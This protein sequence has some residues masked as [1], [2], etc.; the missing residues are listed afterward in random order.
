MVFYFFRGASPL[1]VTRKKCSPL[2]YACT[3]GRAEN[4]DL[5]IKRAKT[6]ICFMIT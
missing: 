2:F 5:L 6:G 4:A 3:A 1:D